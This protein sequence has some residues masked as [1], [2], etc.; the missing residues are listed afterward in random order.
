LCKWWILGHGFSHRTQENQRGPSSNRGDD[1][2]V[3]PL[4]CFCDV[5][6][7]FLLLRQFRDAQGTLKAGRQE[8]AL[9]ELLASKNE[10]KE[11]IG[12][13]DDEENDQHDLDNLLYEM[14]L[15]YFDIGKKVSNPNSSLAVFKF[16]LCPS[17]VPLYFLSCFF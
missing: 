3:K 10:L 1:P 6:L 16:P 9:M 5:Y 11:L 7:I 13:C 8:L 2:N 4:H 12:I 15:K 17:L 14:E